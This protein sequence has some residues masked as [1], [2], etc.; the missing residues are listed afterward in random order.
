MVFAHR[1]QG[2]QDW[3]QP[4]VSHLFSVVSSAPTEHSAY[5]DLTSLSL[6]KYEE[7]E[8]IRSNAR[9]IFELVAFS[10]STRLLVL[11]LDFLSG[12]VIRSPRTAEA[13]GAPVAIPH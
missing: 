9:F 13:E 10:P 7:G 11:V 6:Q 4:G 1:P 3:T 2:L 8:V 5:F 12:V